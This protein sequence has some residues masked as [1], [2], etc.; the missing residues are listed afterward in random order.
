MKYEAVI[1]ANVKYHPG[2][3]R[4]AKQLYTAGFSVSVKPTSTHSIQTGMPWLSGDCFEWFNELRDL[5]KFTKRLLIIDADM[6]VVGDISELF[7]TPTIGFGLVPDH[8]D[9]WQ[10]GVI[11]LNSWDEDWYKI[12]FDLITMIRQKVWQK[13]DQTLLNEY[14]ALHPEIKI[15]ALPSGYSWCSEDGAMTAES[16]ILH[17]HG[18]TK[19]WME[20]YNHRHPFADEWNKKQIYE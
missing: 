2:A 19:P 7:D 10:G 15:T 16:K 18:I 17:F 3:F 1:Y 11:F 5:S 13:G 20:E 6:L 9:K 14:L 8:Y 4:L 12:Y